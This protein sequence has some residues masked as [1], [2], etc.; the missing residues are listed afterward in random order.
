MDEANDVVTKVLRM[1]EWTDQPMD[2][3]SKSV[4]VEKRQEDR[5]NNAKKK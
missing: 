2:T 1:G 4:L 3:P 5:K